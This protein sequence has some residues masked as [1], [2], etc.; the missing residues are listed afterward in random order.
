MTTPTDAKLVPLGVEL[1][2]GGGKH[3]LI[4]EL[5]IRDTELSLKV[6]NYLHTSF[7]KIKRRVFKNLD[8]GGY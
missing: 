3:M 2:E 8:F 7:G 1:I 5:A 6:K 4:L